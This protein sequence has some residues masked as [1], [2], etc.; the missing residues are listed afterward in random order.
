MAKT[1]KIEIKYIAVDQLQHPAYNPRKISAHDFDQLKK[2][3]QEHGFVDPIIVNMAPERRGTVVGGNQRFEAAL[4]LGLKEVPAVF[5]SIADLKEEQA[6][7]V[8]LNRAQGT[9][10]FDKLA[11]NF[12]NQDLLEYGFEPWELD[13]K[14]DG[15]VDEDLTEK[16]KDIYDTN[17]VKQITLYYDDALYAKM[18]EQ[19]NKLVEHMQVTN[20]SEVLQQLV[21]Q[22]YKENDL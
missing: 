11:I 15:P 9:F 2:S 21:E 14:N 6:L 16:K 1:E 5:V 17:A 13:L 22:A 7:C 4:L 3:I 20:Y 10:D 8:R 12:D 18:I 19:M